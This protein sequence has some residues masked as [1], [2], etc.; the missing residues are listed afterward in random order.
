MMTKD[1]TKDITCNVYIIYFN[2]NFTAH[3]H[4]LF[5]KY[6]R[7]PHVVTGFITFT[8]SELVRK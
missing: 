7:T 5:H 3:T 6:Y 8:N 1:I 2:T 4:F